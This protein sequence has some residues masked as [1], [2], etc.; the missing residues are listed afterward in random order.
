MI[1][2]TSLSVSGEVI[3]ILNPSGLRCWTRECPSPKPIN[4]GDQA[5]VQHKAPDSPFW[6][7]M[8]RSVCGG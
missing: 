3:L 2:G 4:E 5:A 6:L 8:I 7:L 1:L